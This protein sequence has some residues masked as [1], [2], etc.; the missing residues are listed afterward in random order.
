MYLIIEFNKRKKFIFYVKIW[1]V[2][3]KIRHENY[4]L[5]DIIVVM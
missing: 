5:S 2:K 3:Y 4:D 1:K